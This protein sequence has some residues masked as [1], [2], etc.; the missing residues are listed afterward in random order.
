MAKIQ[1]DGITD[2]VVID[3]GAQYSAATQEINLREV[4]KYLV[5]HPEF[6]A[7]VT[8][9]KSFSLD[10]RLTELIAKS[11][12]SSLKSQF[13]DVSQND[14]CIFLPVQG[15]PTSLPESSD[16]AIAQMK[17]IVEAMRERFPNNEVFSGFQ[18]HG[19]FPGSAWTQPR[20]QDI[21]QQN[22]QN[23]K[24]ANVLI[25][26]RFS[27]TVDNLETLFDQGVAQVKVIKSANPSAR[28]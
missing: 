23:E 9:I 11:I 1:A 5:A 26:G 18:N 2:L 28:V 8:G 12:E 13:A 7:S 3:Q 25:N 14:V 19:E 15:L 24:C 17:Y 22:G 16:P 21:A 10:S 6:N 20:S 27:F 4:R